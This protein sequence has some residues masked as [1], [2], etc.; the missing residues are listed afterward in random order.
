MAKLKKF[1]QPSK[2]DYERMLKILEKKGRDGF[3]QLG[4]VMIAALGVAGGA[5][6][7]GAVAGAAGVT[8]VA[9]LTTA[10]SWIGFT[11]VA[12]TPVGWIAGCAVAGGA[13]A[14]GISR[15]I[16]NGAKQDER[17]K[18]MAEDIRKKIAEYD[19]NVISMSED[20]QFK[21]AIE[22][23]HTAHIQGRILQEQGIQ[24]IGALKNGDITPQEVVKI[25]DQNVAEVHA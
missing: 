8:S 9:G 11:A 4:D 10:A 21:R 5:L 15:I 3:G 14:Y 12:A 16:R 23:L 18:R 20:D 22:I 19:E 1:K 17:R 24:I 2:D 7:A 25:I 6:S 13:A